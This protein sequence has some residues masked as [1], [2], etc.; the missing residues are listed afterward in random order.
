MEQK[1]Y[2]EAVPVSELPDAD[3]TDSRFSEDSVVFDITGDSQTAYYDFEL[4]KWRNSNRHN[5][6]EVVSYLKPISLSDL[7]KQFASDIWDAA[8]K[9]EREEVNHHISGSAV[10]EPN[11]FDYINS[12]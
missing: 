8:I 9:R 4:K 1:Q 12:L 5:E 2:F 11:K 3:I 6:I 7:K 10:L